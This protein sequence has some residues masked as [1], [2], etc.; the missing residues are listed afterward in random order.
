[1]PSPLIPSPS[2]AQYQLAHTS[3]NLS[4]QILISH[5]ICLP[6]ATVAVILRLVSRHLSKVVHLQAD[7]Y[8]VIAAWVFL[9]SPKPSVNPHFSVRRGH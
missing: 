8:L 7:D 6:L 5:Y 4:S 2:E 1:M 9:S 3:D